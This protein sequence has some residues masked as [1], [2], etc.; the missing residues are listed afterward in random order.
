MTRRKRLRV[1]L[2]VALAA[3]LIFISVLTAA[4]Y[5]S[6]PQI[7]GAAKIS[8]L[9]FPVSIS[10]DSIGHTTVQAQS[11]LDLARATGFV[12]AQERFLSMDIRRRLAAG[13]LAALL[14]PFVL[15]QDR[16]IR[17]H[18][19]REQARKIAAGL[20]E[21]E[22]AILYAYTEGV[23]QGLKALPVW[24]FP[25]AF[26]L[27][28]PEPW[29]PEDSILSL[30]AMHLVLQGG[31]WKYDSVVGFLHETFGADVANFLAPVGSHYDAPLDDT[32][33]PLYTPRV[34]EAHEID[35]RDIPLNPENLKDVRMSWEN[36]G[37][38]AFAVSGKLTSH[39]SALL[40][41]D[42]HLVLLVPNI[43]YRMHWQWA[44]AGKDRMASG[45]TLPG[46]PWLIAGSN[47]QIAWGFTNSNVDTQD[48]IVLDPEEP[49]L[50]TVEEVLEVRLGADE[51]L[52][53]EISA[54]GPV[55]G[56]DFQNRKRA[57]RWAAYWLTGTHINFSQLEMS[58]DI[59]S[60][61]T[62]FQQSAI[63]WQNV[64]IVDREGNLG[65]TIAGA[66]P[67][68][69]G[70]SGRI[71][72]KSSML[73][74]HAPQWLPPAEYPVVFNPPGHRLWSANSRHVGGEYYA[75]LGDGRYTA[76]MRAQQIRN[77][78]R[79][80]TVFSES[81]LL[82]LQLDNR[83]DYLN[84]WR[85]RL[86]RAMNEASIAP[87]VER[88]RVRKWLAEWDGHSNADSVGYRI[89]RTFR[90]RAHELFLLALQT[91]L[92]L[93]PDRHTRHLR[94]QLDSP[95]TRIL[96][97]EAQNFL[98]RNMQNWDEFLALALKLTIEDM[99]VGGRDMAEATWGARNYARIRHPL[100]HALPFLGGLLDAP[101]SPLSGDLNLPRVAHRAFGA[102]HRTVVSPGREEGGIMNMPTGQSGHPLSPFY[103]AGH[104]DWLEGKPTPFL[105]GPALTTMT[106]A[107]SEH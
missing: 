14:G 78:L 65:W 47:G 82:A 91:Q 81:D 92:G 29:K 52:T 87:L 103:N 15:E 104:N 8:G 16:E 75:L 35:L 34:P 94:W 57:L 7:S 58:E 105:P 60:A 72:I 25:Y 101:P 84:E 106:L 30:F 46:L 6:R 68:R 55:I 23:N 50:A 74:S 80:K 3:V 32:P 98:P 36:P 66:L 42:M 99:T 71:P 11:R 37:S 4:L 28:R 44:D 93:S 79:E 86:E 26:F 56:K 70:Y 27:T 31:H 89:I 64:L 69:E 102:S 83:A 48:L 17:L 63:P 67:R 88:H 53:Y 62:L 107:P 73:E 1:A 33:I 100:S 49:S 13:E 9:D 43:W 21:T 10:R 54:W 41:N 38:N 5:L 24:P 40:A 12:H 77:R 59:R 97:S 76:G 95:L 20:S 18:R 61:M 51:K 45:L 22:H 39:G 96:A 90:K 2:W 85:P 19:F